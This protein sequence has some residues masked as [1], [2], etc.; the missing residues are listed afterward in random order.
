MQLEEAMPKHSKLVVTL[1]LALA[2]VGLCLWLPARV[3]YAGAP[4]N[5]ATSG[6]RRPLSPA[7][8]VYTVNTTS[9][10]VLMSGCG[11]VGTCSLRGAIQ[12][13]NVIGSVYIYFAP[14][15]N[16]L[17]I[18]LGST[19][20]VTNSL[21]IYG[22]G[23]DR[24]SI[25]APSNQP[26]FTVQG[27]DAFMTEF[28][29]IGGLT[30]SGS[31][32]HGVL[33]VS[34]SSNDLEFLVLYG[35]GGSGIVI[36]SAAD[37]TLLASNTIGVPHSQWSGTCA[38]GNA[39]YGVLNHGSKATML[40]NVIGCNDLDGIAFDGSNA[41]L[42]LLKGNHVGVGLYSAL[43]PNGHSGIA[44]VNGANDN[45]I[46]TSSDG[47][48]V[49]GN[50]QHGI[51]I[52]DTGTRNN[53]V[54]NNIIGLDVNGV[55]ANGNGGNGVTIANTADS[56]HIG[57]HVLTESNVIAGNTGAGILI[58]G[59]GAGNVSDTRYN[60]IVGN[61][62]GTN[63]AGN[64]A[65]PNGG[66]GLLVRNGAWANT[67]G[68]GNDKDEN[69]FSGNGGDGITVLGARGN[70]F[71]H[72]L[73]GVVISGSGVISNAQNGIRLDNG[74]TQNGF[75]DNLL[76]SNAQSGAVISGTTTMSNSLSGNLIHGNMLY[77]V[78]LLHGT[79]ANEIDSNYID[80]SSA[81]G[82]LLDGAG[83]S[84]NLITGTESMGSFGGAGIRERNGAT[85]NVWS[86]LNT[87]DNTGLDIDK[88]PLG[89]TP[90]FPTVISTTV[91]GG[92]VT[93]YGKASPAFFQSVKIELYS[94]R[95]VD[96]G[97]GF[98]SRI[99][100]GTTN[101]DVNGDWSLTYS[102]TRAC[103]IAFQTAT[104]AF[105][106]LSASSEYGPNSCRLFLPLVT[107]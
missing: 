43:L 38:V 1:V 103:Y 22:P 62:V 27:N 68:D 13:G 44:L 5:T 102:G 73:V 45:D 17:T 77:G 46:G 3:S 32:Q 28:S 40:D 79:R 84:R 6:T 15:L 85:N 21:N 94:T 95:V 86:H 92:N 4:E 14:S 83:T 57:G 50:M 64:K 76:F 30:G 88:D 70:T 81:D 35:L 36:Q 96:V 80:F 11:G 75:R 61:N 39:G 89:V 100:Y 60:L 55:N 20:L 67:I 12:K 98:E 97:F 18:T 10:A 42:G 24:L 48:V 2:L 104:N 78:A 25:A 37:S 56:N 91:N 106:G 54:A 34:G 105:S 71:F 29:I 33:I 90:P 58:D 7:V 19:L 52:A 26:A 47:N 65:V 63:K 72:N 99:Y 31:S 16:G 23:R 41:T 53:R 87:H 59:I 74:A 49:S 82:I 9:D 66:S 8:A 101:A 69:T 51:Y 93:V 107:R